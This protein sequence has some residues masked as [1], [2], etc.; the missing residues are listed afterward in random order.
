[1]RYIVFENMKPYYNSIVLVCSKDL[2]TVEPEGE[3]VKH[4]YGH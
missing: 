4:G 2:K 3:S 1:M